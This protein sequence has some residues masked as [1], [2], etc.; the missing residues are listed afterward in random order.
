MD[1]IQL[2]SRKALTE[3]CRRWQI[4]EL[5]V[6][7]SVARGSFRSDS[8]VDLLAT[9]RPEAPWSTLDFVDLREDLSG[10]FGRSIDLVEEKAIRNPWRK[11]SILR[12]KSVLYAA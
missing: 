10:L 6:F 8:D 5:S 1:T 3:L 2:P 4:V 7:G 12:D 11:A 9:F